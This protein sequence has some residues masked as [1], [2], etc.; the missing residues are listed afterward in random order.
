[1]RVRVG[2]NAEAGISGVILVGG[3][4]R[5]LGVD[6]VVLC[7][8]GRPLVASAAE[9]LK[10]VTDELLAVGSHRDIL[11]RL[12]LRVVDDVY[13]GCGVLGGIYTGLRASRFE[14]A[15]IV[16]GDMPFLSAPLLN[17]MIGL[18][19]DFDVVIPRTPMGLEPL[20]AIYSK[21]CL[22]PIDDLL[23]AGVLRII[24]FF[25]EVRVR[26]VE[27]EEILPFDPHYRSFLNVNTPED[28]DKAREV[29]EALEAQDRSG[30]ESPA[31]EHTNR[32][33]N[34]RSGS[35]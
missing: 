27:P 19:K 30:T 15:L 16:A 17:Y 13:P 4:S 25:H 20:H 32:A 9:K 18:A 35:S 31:Q 11:D 7:F 8:G 22:D 24:R 14:K 10:C 12:G 29:A 23:S 6:K 3:D 26:Y 33:D 5:R 2:A 28:L 1:M 21:A 34:A